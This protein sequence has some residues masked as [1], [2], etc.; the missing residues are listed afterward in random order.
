MRPLHH[1][2]V[3]LA[4][5]FVAGTAAARP[6]A[7]TGKTPAPSRSRHASTLATQ[8]RRASIATPSV[9]APEPTQSSVVMRTHRI[10]RGDS[11]SGIAV[12]YGTSVLALAAA[13]GLDPHDVI[14]TGQELVIPQ[15]ARP[16]AGNDWIKYARSA[17]EGGKLD[18]LAYK[19]R[20]QGRV[21]EKGRLVPAARHSISE[22]LGAG[23][24]HPPV[25]ER[26]IRLLVRVSD[27]FGGR[28]I[29]VV[30]G[31]RTSS[32]FADSRHKHSAA[33]D[34]SIPGVPNAVLRQ[35]LLMF[36]DVGVGYYPNSS[37]V[38]LDVR[39]G[40]TQWVDY[41]GPGEAPRL[42]PN[43]PR[44]A[45]GFGHS[46]SVSDLDEIAESVVAAMNGSSH[47]HAEMPA[48]PA[49]PDIVSGEGRA[50][51]DEPRGGVKARAGQR[52]DAHGTAPEGGRDGETS[53]DSE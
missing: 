35:Y 26:L 22:L 28:Q 8:S 2:S 13:N 36:E 18:L 6:P 31:Y 12:E 37:F 32:Y 44:F 25:P 53:P 27:T 16:G 41:A 49:A 19:T 51:S 14:R 15:P 46:P 4:S 7:R 39:D 23:G 17:K 48:T 50:L 24:E 43:A 45:H 10:V 9:R 34:F 30:S 11:L 1:F 5:L 38:H 20:Y 52:E 29:R 42:H 21:I 3:L 40:A 33:V 47:Q